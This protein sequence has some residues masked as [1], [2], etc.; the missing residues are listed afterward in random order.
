MSKPLAERAESIPLSSIAPDARDLIR[1]YRENGEVSFQDVPLATAREN[2]ARGCEAN[3]LPR[4]ECAVVRDHEVPVHGGT[5][6]VREYRGS[7]AE[8]LPPVLF[9]HGGGWVIGSL[10]THDAVCRLLARESEAAVYAVDYRLAPEHPFPGPFEDCSAVLRWLVENAKTL[11]ID[12]LRLAL[13]GDS[14]GGNLAAVLAN[15]DEPLPQGCCLR[16]QVLFY[17]VTDLRGDT[18]SY[19]RIVSGFPLTAGSMRWFRNHYVGPG[20][21]WDDPRL[22]PLLAP[23]LSLAPMFLLSCGLDPL[24]DEGVAYAARAIAAGVRVEHHH[25]PAHA[26]GIVTSAGRIGTGRTMTIRA[27]SFLRETLQQP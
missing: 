12:P 14:A 21:A 11:G 8:M 9:M 1:A 2:Y 18:A 23:R 6:L 10:D 15:S 27:A 24:A 26:H 20:T 13:A 5:I 19:R 4:T 16:A 25:L 17:P 3:G 22:S 7:A